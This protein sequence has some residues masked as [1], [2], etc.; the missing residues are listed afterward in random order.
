MQTF[1]PE[2]LLAA[3]TL[4]DKTQEDVAAA[5]HMEQPLI[6]MIES[7]HR[8]FTENH[9]IA[10]ADAMNLPLEFFS[11]RPRSIPF[12]S[13]LFRKNKTSSNRVTKRVRVHFQEGFRVVEDLLDGTGYPTPP[14]PTIQ[15][16]DDVLAIARIEE[17]ADLVRSAFRLDPDAPVPNVTRVLE[18]HGFV[19]APMVLASTE[20]DPDAQQPGHYGVSYWAGRSFPGMIG[21]F[22]GSSAD[23][24]RF[25]LAHELGHAVLHSDR[26]SSDPEIEAN[27]FAGAFLMPSGRARP[28]LSGDV[29]LAQLARIKAEWGISIQALVM[30]GSQAGYFPADRAQ[31]LYR[32]IS[33][34]GWRKKE[35]VEVI[36]ENPKLFYRLLVN[37]FGTDPFRNREIEQSTALPLFVLRSLAPNPLTSPPVRESEPGGKLLQFTPRA[38]P[39]KRGTQS[40]SHPLIYEN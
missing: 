21:F 27:L 35:P 40:E 38:Q 18:R 10:L 36:A 20:M 23:R 39:R 25:T 31:T 1:F 4:L 7:H 30:R 5:A 33:S 34:R 26:T 12:D 19:V 14:L 29:T 32:Q 15:D 22:P 28:L 9:A 6:S 11:V 2:R 13:L 17:I 37:R 8:A 16:E 24:D 3:R